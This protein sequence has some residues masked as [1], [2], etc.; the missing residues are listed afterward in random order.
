MSDHSGTVTFRGTGLKTLRCAVNAANPNYPNPPAWGLGYYVNG[1]ESPAVYV[2]RGTEYTLEA[3]GGPTHPVYITD[4]IIGG[5]SLDNYVGERVFAGNDTTYG[6]L[7]FQIC[8]IVLQFV[9]S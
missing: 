9:D 7:L 4:S 8:D 2:R 3:A 1:L 6:K 5:G